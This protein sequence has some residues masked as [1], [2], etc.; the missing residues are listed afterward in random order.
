MWYTYTVKPDPDLVWYFCDSASELGMRAAHISDDQLCGSNVP[1]QKWPTAR[2]CKAVHRQREIKDALFQL[3]YQLQSVLECA[4]TPQ[5]ITVQQRHEHDLV[6]PLIARILVR[7][8]GA[9]ADEKR[10]MIATTQRLLDAGHAAFRIAYG[11]LP[12]SSRRTAVRHRAER[13]MTEDG[14]HA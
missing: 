2:M 3:S 10:S 11:Q 6:A 1:E 5:G 12:A 4:Y 7:M 14:L 9:P 8:S 13:W